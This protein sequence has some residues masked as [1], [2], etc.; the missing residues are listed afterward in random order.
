[1]RILVDGD[2]CP[3]IDIIQETAELYQAELI[4]YTDLNHQHK[5][6]YGKLL[7]VDQGYQSVDMELYNNIRKDDIIV[8]SDY[9]LAALALSKQADVI[10]FSGREFTDKNIERLLLQRHIHFKERRKTGRHT[11]HKKRTDKDDK[12]FKLKLENK[13]SNH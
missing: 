3:V 12:R 10:S 5:L 4:V 7:T 8:T 11:T 2:G 13:L 6:E 9:G 1:M